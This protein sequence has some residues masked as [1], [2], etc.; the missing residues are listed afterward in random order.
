MQDFTIDII[1]QAEITKV[2]QASVLWKAVEPNL[3]VLTEF[4]LP[5]NTVL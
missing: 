2:A 1:M 5:F 3:L 4:G